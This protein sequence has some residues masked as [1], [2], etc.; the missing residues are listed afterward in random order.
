M[1][2]KS[3][4]AIDEGLIPRSRNFSRKFNP[5]DLKLSGS[6]LT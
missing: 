3:A 1:K 6:L 4:I 5:Q 2:I